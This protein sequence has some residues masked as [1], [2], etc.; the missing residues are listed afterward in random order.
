MFDYF[1]NF[2]NLINF[3]FQY[4]HPT[5]YLFTITSTAQLN[6]NK[7]N[8]GKEQFKP[9][10]IEIG[11]NGD[12]ALKHKIQNHNLGFILLEFL[13]NFDLIYNCCIKYEEKISNSSEIGE[14]KTA[15]DYSDFFIVS[16]ILDDL[17]EELSRIK[18]IKHCFSILINEIKTFNTNFITQ[19][20][21][22]TDQ[23]HKEIK[24]AEEEMSK[25]N[26]NRIFAPVSKEY[27]QAYKEQ[28]EELQTLKFYKSVYLKFIKN[29]NSSLK[30]LYDFCIKTFIPTEKSKYNIRQTQKYSGNKLIVPTAELIFNHNYDECDTIKIDKFIYKVTTIQEIANITLY[31]IVQNKNVL[32]KCENCGDY[33]I[34]KT[35]NNEKYC[36]KY[37]KI[38]EDDTKLYCRNVGK[39]RSYSTKNHNTSQL[40]KTL[41]DRINKNISSANCD[42]KILNEKLTE[43][44]NMYDK[45]KGKYKDK[46]TQNYELHKY[47]VEFDKE[48]QKEF[49]SNRYSSKK[50]WKYAN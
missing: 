37:I 22:Y 44:K 28:Y 26:S 2:K 40:Y 18:K 10:G 23:L 45:I 11:I 21:K 1:S 47:L 49:P 39:Y 34:P 15:D 3:K 12:I 42:E 19:I 30:N 38:A 20:T 8:K 13:N 16:Y 5:T 6:E 25:E 48:F 36:D 41:K 32:K 29:F 24:I 35:R 33:F 50:Y 46:S 43:L 17:M 31:H 14:L 4:G 7:K 9:L 27:L